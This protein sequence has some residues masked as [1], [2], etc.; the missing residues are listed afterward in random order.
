[1]LVFK[2]GLY[3]LVINSTVAIDIRVYEN[4]FNP[5]DVN[6][7][8]LLYSYGRCSANQI[9]FNINLRPDHVYYLIVAT[10]SAYR[11]ALFSAVS[12]GS[13]RIRFEQSSEYC[14]LC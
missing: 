11:K 10:T 6:A 4:Y 7:N 2:S 13:S 8:L 5:L 1:M 12:I 3:D 9:K 14:C